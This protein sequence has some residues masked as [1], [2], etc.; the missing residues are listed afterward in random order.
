[1][2]VSSNLSYARKALLRNE[3]VVRGLV[4]IDRSKVLGSQPRTPFRR[5]AGS[6]S[7]HSGAG[8][9]VHEGID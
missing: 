1:M 6:V 7:R 2:E 8:V 9:L 5:A 4:T 3:S